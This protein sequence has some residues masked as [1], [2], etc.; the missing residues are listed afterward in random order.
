MQV[1]LLGDFQ[2]RYGGEPVTTLD[3]SRLQSLLAY[4]LLN[5]ATSQLRHHIAFQFWPDTAE[6]QA[7]T[8]LRKLILL[9]RRALPDAD[10]CLHITNN[11]IQWRPDTPLDL[12]VAKFEQ[13]CAAEDSPESWQT[14]VYLYRGQL[15]PSCYDDWILP[16]RERLHQ[17]YVETA[18]RLIDRLETDQDFKQ[19]IHYA[20]HLLR[21]EPMRETTYRKLMRLYVRLGERSSALRTYH[22]CTTVL[23]RELDVE[24]SEETQA[25]YH[26]LMHR[27]TSFSASMPDTAPSPADVPVAPTVG[28]LIG[29]VAEWQEL[30]SLWSNLKSQQSRFVLITGEAGIGKSH[31]AEHYL[32]W[33][34]NRG[35]TVARTRSWSGE[36]RL[37]YSAVAELLR[38]EGVR[39]L[40][41]DL[42]DLWLEHIL[43]LLPELRE[44]KPHLSIPA[45]LQEDWQRQQF[46]DSLTRAVTA[47]H[48]P[49]LLLFDDLQ[50]SDGQTL[51]WLHYLLRYRYDQPLL[52]VGTARVGAKVDHEA[53]ARFLLSLRHSDQL[54]E[55]ELNPLDHENVA[56]LA[57]QI[58]GQELEVELT[59]KLYSRTEGN[60]LFVVEAVRAGIGL[61]DV[62]Q[63]RDDVENVVNHSM[64]PKIAAVIQSRFEQL[65]PLA[66]ELASIAAVIGRSFTFPV[67]AVAAKHDEAALIL[68]LDEL[69]RRRVVRELEAATYDFSH[70]YLREFI[71]DHLSPM[72]R[73]ILHRN[74]AQALEEVYRHNTEEV[75]GELAV[76]FERAGVYDQATFYL[77][78]AGKFA[79]DNYAFEEATHHFQRALDL[80]R[81]DESIGQAHLGLSR[82]HFALDAPETALH[83]VEL[84]KHFVEEQSQ[85]S[86]YLFHLEAEIL[87]AC[88]EIDLARSAALT[89]QHIAESIGDQVTVCQS[90]S[91]LG[92]TYSARGEVD[93]EAKLIKRALSICRQ[94]KNRWREGRT[95]ADLGWLQ[96]QRGEFV[97][98][99]ASADQ[100]RQ[101]LSMTEDHAGLAFAWNV[102]G[103]AYGGSGSYTAAFAAFQ[104]S[105]KL[106]AAIDHKF[107]LAQVPNMMGW[108][109]Q[110]LC[111]YQQALAFD[112][113]GVD[114]ARDWDKM[115]AEIS[116]RINVALDH[117][118]LGNPEQA[119]AQLMQIQGQVEQMNH[120]FHTW[121]WRLRLLH[122]QGL[123]QLAR[124]KPDAARALAGQGLELSRAT[125]SS[126][127]VALNQ[128]L[129]GNAS[130]A[131]GQKN[132]AV[133]AL[134]SAVELADTVSYQPLR[135]DG[136]WSLAT[137]TAASGNDETARS[138]LHQAKQ[139]INK[140][141]DGL[142]DI[143]L[144][145]T[146]IQST[147]VQAILQADKGA[148]G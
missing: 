99:V 51:E 32:H 11:S 17:M 97:D 69:W 102:L 144:Q 148:A 48:K 21:Q 107:L 108:L 41:T 134:T 137:I 80:T 28:S 114:L 10:N 6:A 88:Y 40:I 140:I 92:Q 89:A 77:L 138:W 45:P 18:D 133:S 135:W 37:A 49:L 74:V 121:R 56:M 4:L 44:E 86:A 42:N 73:H 76:H 12:D 34:N 65:S 120:G 131:L 38:S 103:R 5:R 90:L 81:E 87:F 20:E 66:Q 8:N 9:L 63:A 14:A 46:F 78:R 70:D 101:I 43:R 57:N 94:T 109:Y 98:A 127:Y 59:E 55:I 26:Q 13:N 31:L 104:Q 68:G 60:P 141:A 36:G 142:D 110:Q 79:L 72:R 25:L 116:A 22:S 122:A 130:L 85:L 128:A 71:Y 23:Q 123:S 35:A 53:L 61:E 54:S 29:R 95:L 15:L 1:W 96:A 30:I 93:T 83:H 136:R 75:Y 24:P 119:L 132:A 125:S 106:A 2:L 62:D 50:W 117:L 27:G 19:A 146:F 84:A 52:I 33:A 111:D 143:S 39:P 118:Y 47:H 105:Q 145:S 129:L 91:L 115:P 7:R 112:Q 64:P 100:A 58:A 16:V 147:S 3:A 124:Q 126:K 82:A 67:L 139:V 113:E